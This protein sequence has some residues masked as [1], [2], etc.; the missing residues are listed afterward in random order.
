[1]SLVA[2][3]PVEVNNFMRL[4]CISGM[5]HC[6]DGDSA[7]QI[8][9]TLQGVGNLMSETLDPKWNVLTA[10]VRWVEEGVAPDTILGTKYINDTVDLCVQ[11]TRRHCHYPLGNT[12]KG[13]GDDG[14]PNS[15]F[16]NED[17]SV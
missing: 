8:G 13:T 5:S 10:L 15:W 1:M 12:Y 7:W 3:P 14:D 6:A 4:F 17:Y 11:F 2:L 9:Q 16:A